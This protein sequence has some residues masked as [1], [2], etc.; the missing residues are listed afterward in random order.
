MVGPLLGI[1]KITSG[2]EAMISVAGGRGYV[3]VNGDIRGAKPPIVFIHGGPGSSHWYFLNATALAG[4]RAV[5]L[6]DQ[7]D[8]GRSDHSGDP[9]NFQVPRF[10]SELENIRA[11]LGVDRWHVLGASWEGTVGLEYAVRYPRV[12]ASLI[13]PSP[14]I[15]TAVWLRDART[16]NDSIPP[17][18]RRVLDA[19][20]TP[21][22]KQHAMPR[23][24]PFMRATYNA[25]SRRPLS[26]RIR[27]R[28]HAVS[29]H[30][31]M[32]IR[33]AVPNLRHR[34]R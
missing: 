22:P 7:L 34:A 19:C 31:Y 26:L 23:P 24:M 32:N 9:A 33:G 11:A 21:C 8:S 18:E 27:R 25:P 2:R 5:I 20:D 29:A 15:S 6:C 12:L 30:I 13:L 16:L 4:D 28:Y 3:R 14:L 10:V 1:A 17:G